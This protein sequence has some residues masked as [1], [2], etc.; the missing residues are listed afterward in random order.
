MPVDK[1]IEREIVEGIIRVIWCPIRQTDL[2]VERCATFINEG[3][4]DC[5][6]CGYQIKAQYNSLRIRD[7]IK[8]KD[9]GSGGHYKRR[10]IFGDPLPPAPRG[11]P[12]KTKPDDDP[13]LADFSGHR[14][15]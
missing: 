2:A 11:R 4:E 15:G 6:Q 5:L 10:K 3:R 8:L 13:P 14:E 1:V 12:R 9:R 7:R